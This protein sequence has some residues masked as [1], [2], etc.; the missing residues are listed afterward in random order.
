M[1]L[2]FPLQERRSM[3]QS[4]VVRQV[5]EKFG[6]IQVVFAHGGIGKGRNTTN[7]TPPS[8]TAKR[9]T[10]ERSTLIKFLVEKKLFLKRPSWNFRFYIFS[11]WVSIAVH[12]YLLEFLCLPLLEKDGAKGI[13]RHVAYQRDSS[14]CTQRWIWI[15]ICA[16]VTSVGIHTGFGTQA[17]R[18]QKFKSMAAHKRTSEILEKNLPFSPFKSLQL[19]LKHSQGS[20]WCV[21]T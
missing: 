12:M 1:R 6:L 14:C 17:R 19:K 10:C 13:G 20:I 9:A 15:V 11:F 7:F 18:H 8:K 16:Q 5:V 21:Q 2:L 4:M 3:M